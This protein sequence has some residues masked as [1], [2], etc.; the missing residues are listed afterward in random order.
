MRACFR[1]EY[2]WCDGVRFQKPIEL[3]AP[4]YVDFLMIW[5]QGLL[6]DPHVFPTRLGVA[7]PKNFASV[8][9]TIFKRLF[10]VYAH[11][12]L[13]HFSKMVQ[14][15]QEAHI[16]TSFRHFYY[17]VKEFDLIVEKKELAPL[18]DLI[19]KID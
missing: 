6:D 17:F 19:K 7:F 4:Q 3:N 15:G 11:I 9:R 5:I 12:Y 14:L 8:V 13:T 1:F 10:R 18:M 2:L 16:N